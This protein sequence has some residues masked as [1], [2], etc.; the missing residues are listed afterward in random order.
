[1][2]FAKF[3]RKMPLGEASIDRWRTA[4]HG[5]GRRIREQAAINI[6]QF[7]DSAESG[8]R[9]N[10]KTMRLRQKTAVF[11]AMGLLS[12]NAFA[13]PSGLTN[14]AVSPGS[15]SLWDVFPGANYQPGYTFVAIGEPL[16]LN[17]TNAGT[18]SGPVDA[19]GGT[20]PG[21]RDQ[22]YTFFATS[23]FNIA[24]TAD[25]NL[26]TVVLQAKYQ[27]GGGGGLLNVLFNGSTASSVVTG[28]A[29]TDPGTD[30]QR[31]ITTWTWENINVSQGQAI[32]LAWEMGV[33]STFDA[34]QLDLVA[35]PEPGTL[36]FL[37]VGTAALLG[38]ARRRSRAQHPGTE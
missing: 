1:M 29:F 9:A 34:V 35:V 15:I 12:I 25:T 32:N 10:F 19:D 13:T 28:L 37:A 2:V 27:P 18:A 8:F 20:V 23:A 7:N 6:R 5:S 30:Y 3:T 14:Y 21:N 31:Q 26:Q 33:H 22:Y 36:A 16:S 24:D 17:V 11:L 4:F 38:L